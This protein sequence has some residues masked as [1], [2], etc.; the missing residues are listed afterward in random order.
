MKKFI[1]IMIVLAASV[2]AVLLYTSFR[3]HSFKSVNI[4]ETNYIVGEGLAFEW[5]TMC[6]SSEYRVPRRDIYPNESR[7]C[8]ANSEVAERSTYITYLQG[9]NQCETHK[10]SA[11]FLFKSNSETRC[12]KKNEINGTSIIVEDDVMRFGSNKND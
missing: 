8:A 6:V 1:L 12:F 7:S 9:Y 10:I 5:D 11:S 3:D 2:I 4:A